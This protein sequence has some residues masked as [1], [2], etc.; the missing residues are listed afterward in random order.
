MRG[1]EKVLAQKSGRIVLLSS[2]KEKSKKVPAGWDIPHTNFSVIEPK[3]GV[4]P[5][6]KILKKE[7]NVKTKQKKTVST[8][9]LPKLLPHMLLN[10]Q[11]Y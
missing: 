7:L 11:D 10:I 9:N 1:Q 8:K 4:T 6:M 5:R 2:P 3:E